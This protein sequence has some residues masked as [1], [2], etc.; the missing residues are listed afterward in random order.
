[1]IIGNSLVTAHAIKAT[2]L[3]LSKLCL[4]SLAKN[5]QS[6]ARLITMP[7]LQNR[8]QQLM[9]GQQSRLN[10]NASGHSGG[11]RSIQ[12]DDSNSLMSIPQ[13][14]SVMLMTKFITFHE[15]H[16]IIMMCIE[17]FEGYEY[18]TCHRKNMQ[19]MLAYKAA[20]NSQTSSLV[21]RSEARLL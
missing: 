20:E 3:S 19:M 5:I 21:G 17:G 15:K 14:T 12:D 9:G 16:C 8:N 7:Y 10:D 1:M 6:F 18:I 11:K 2:I 4:F 13:Y